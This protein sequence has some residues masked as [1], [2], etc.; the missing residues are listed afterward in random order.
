MG[1]CSNEYRLC[2]YMNILCASSCLVLLDIIYNIISDIGIKML[3]QG[4]NAT[5]DYSTISTDLV[6]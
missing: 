5:E 3:P 2:A 6:Y 1:S 4:Q